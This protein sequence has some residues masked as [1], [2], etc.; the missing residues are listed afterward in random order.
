MLD[1]GE[2]QRGTKPQNTLIECFRGTKS[3][4]HN[5]PLPLAKGKGDKGG[6]GYYIKPKEVM[7]VNSLR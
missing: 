7:P 4:S 2:S 6:W 5:L 3:L 1:L